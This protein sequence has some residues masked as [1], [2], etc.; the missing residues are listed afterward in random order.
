MLDGD[1]EPQS[2]H[3]NVVSGFILGTM[4]G[5]RRRRRMGGAVMEINVKVD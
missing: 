1:S 5:R 3:S 2:I 4:D